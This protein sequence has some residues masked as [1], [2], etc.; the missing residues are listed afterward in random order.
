MLKEISS[1]FTLSDR[2]TTI[3]FIIIIKRICT[4]IFLSVSGEIYLLLL[5]ELLS[6]FVFRLLVSLLLALAFS[7][8]LYFKNASL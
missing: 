7:L 1:N 5:G 3:T 2:F 4:H 8:F 6:F